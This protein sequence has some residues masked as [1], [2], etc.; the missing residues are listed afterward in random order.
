MGC[1]CSDG[2]FGC[3]YDP[4]DVLAFFRHDGSIP[5]S[6]NLDMGGNDIIN[7]NDVAIGGDLVVTGSITA[8]EY[9]GGSPVHL[10]EDSITFGTD[11]GASIGITT[12]EIEGGNIPA[13]AFESVDEDL[14]L[15]MKSV[16]DIALQAAASIRLISD[17]DVSLQGVE[18]SW[19]IIDV[20]QVM[21]ATE[22]GITFG[23][24]AGEA[25][26]FNIQF[27][28]S[29]GLAGLDFDHINSDTIIYG[30]DITFDSVTQAAF[31]PNGGTYVIGTF[32]VTGE[33]LL[34]GDLVVTGS[35][36]SSIF[37]DSSLRGFYQF[38]SD[39]SDS[40]IYSN[41]ADGVVGTPT[42]TTNVLGLDGSSGVD[43]V[44]SNVLFP[45]DNSWTQSLWFQSDMGDLIS[46]EAFILQG[47]RNGSGGFGSTIIR[48][49]SDEDKLEFAYRDAENNFTHFNG[50][51]LATLGSDWHH[52]IVTYDGT[53]FKMYVDGELFDTQVDDFSGFGSEVAYIGYNAVPP[54]NDFFEGQLDDVMIFD[55]TL[56][57]QEIYQIY[58]AQNK[59]YGHFNDIWQ[60]GKHH[61]RDSA[62]GTY[63]Q[64]DGFW[65][66]FADGGM[67]FGDS[68][69]GAPT[70]FANFA[71]NGL[72]TLVGTARVKN[73]MIF[74]AS[75]AGLGV[76]TPTL[77]FRDIGAS[78]GVKKE[79]LQFSKTIQNDAYTEFHTPHSLDGSENVA[80]HLMWIPG[81]AWTTGNYI[82]KFEYVVKNEDDPTNTGTPTTI[83]MDVTPANAI[84][85]I[86][87]VF[88]TTIDIG[89]NQLLIGHFY[90]D[91]GSDNADDVG[92]INF[93]EVE[94]TQDKL[95]VAA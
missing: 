34:T 92:E 84:D 52:V 7:A 28:N 54:D 57:P 2:D 71:P 1:G 18:V 33:T 6:G 14:I 86:E 47:S 37:Q 43:L 87:T 62:I 51:T 46:N 63:S 17:E 78:G 42:Y 13:W 91:V 67:R 90:R 50:P 24:I 22:E 88:S 80:F 72:L 55:R 25:D 68:S 29:Q 65:D 20:G 70:N 75:G 21:Q 95:G 48:F 79:V 56:T 69:A 4:I 32:D 82:W 10:R 89:P 26:P 12:V 64:A 8:G 53:T 9:L 45:N 30:G 11:D 35:I 19:D 23:D 77:A 36:T 58:E 49:R 76:S 16:T 93:F 81:A 85:M 3:R 94:Y 38:V 73:E 83:T 39:P 44:A 40:S 60:I 31:F 61:F 5:M 41:D 66:C 74:T 15:A 27:I 59:R